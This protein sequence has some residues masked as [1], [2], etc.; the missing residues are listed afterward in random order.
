MLSVYFHSVPL[1]Y[2]NWVSNHKGMARTEVADGENRLQIWRVVANILN[3]QWRAADNSGP[4]GLSLAR[5]A[6]NTYSKSHLSNEIL[7]RP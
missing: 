7:C 2:Y 6:T 3:K 5:N 4:S 1:V